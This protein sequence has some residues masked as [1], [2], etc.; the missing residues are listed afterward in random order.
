MKKALITGITGQDGSYLAQLLLKKN[1]QVIGLVSPHN[2]I[3]HH[4]IKDFENKLIL[5]TGDLL[6]YQSL[7]SIILKYQPDQIYNL[8]GISFIPTS[9]QKPLLTHDVNALGPLRILDIIK[10]NNLK[11]KFLQ[12]SSAKIFAQGKKAKLNETS[13]LGPSDPY[14]VSK[15]DA[16][17]TTQ[18][19]RSQGL[20]AATAILFNHE[21]EKRGPEF[22]SRKITQSAAKIKLGLETKLALGNLKSQGD[23]G[24]APD[25]VIGMWQILDHK[26]PDDFV[27]ATGKLHTVSHICQ[28]AFSYLGLNF[29]D[30]VHRDDQFWRP[31]PKIAYYGDP[32]KAETVLSWKRSISFEKMIQKMVDYDLALLKNKK[33]Q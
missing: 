10:K 33:I 29:K 18:L 16:H 31:A 28:T 11:T 30:Y 3:G 23:W 22:V 6:D 19:F 20:F 12:A 1:Y 25:Y 15:L 27:L 13:P 24:Y 17:L 21:S 14:G 9:W 26:K 4:N 5:E 2:D 32:S 8:A 7:K